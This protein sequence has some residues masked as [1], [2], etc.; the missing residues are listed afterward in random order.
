MP[1]RLLLSLALRLF[2]AISR[3]CSHQGPNHLDD[4]DLF[5]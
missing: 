5:T 3:A 1:P 4:H 2:L